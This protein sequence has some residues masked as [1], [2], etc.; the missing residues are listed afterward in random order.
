MILMMLGLFLILLDIVAE[1]LKLDLATLT[2]IK[3]RECTWS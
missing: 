1:R 3:K 2:N